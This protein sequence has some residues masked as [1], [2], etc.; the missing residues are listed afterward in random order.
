[1]QEKYMSTQPTKHTEI[2]CPWDTQRLQVALAAAHYHAQ[3]G[4][5]RLH[6]SGVDRKDLR[7]DILLALLQQSDHFDPAKGAWSTF[8]A[9]IARHAVADRERV[10]RLSHRPEFEP[11]EVDDFPAG[12]SAAQQDVD[13]PTQL[14]NL[15]RVADELPQAPQKVLRLLGI[16]GDVA[17]A[18]R[19]SPQSC[20]SFYRA[21]ADLRF[22]LR[23]SGLRPTRSA[24]RAHAT[25]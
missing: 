20:A 10:E 6:L 18:Q 11:I 14:L 16:T 7:Q 4:G 23:A 1:M 5:R 21:I 19:N 3:R 17:E 15:Q 25:L 22:W 9:V 13:D 24:T 8:V 12:S 2:Q